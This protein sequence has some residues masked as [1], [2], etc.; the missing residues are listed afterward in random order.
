MITR[1]EEE[2]IELKLDIKDTLENVRNKLNHINI[3]LKEITYFDTI[4]EIKEGL[5]GISFNLS[6]TN[7]VILK[8]KF[9]IRCIIENI[10]RRIEKMYI[11]EVKDNE[12]RNKSAN[13]LQII[14]GSEMYYG[15]YVDKLQQRID[16]AIELCNIILKNEPLENN[17]N[18]DLIDQITSIKSELLKGEDKEC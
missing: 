3:N 17:P 9:V 8:E 12:W 10:F 1:N 11:K 6:I 2:F 5:H 16:K 15:W 13:Y 7:R 18:Y 14:E 4:L